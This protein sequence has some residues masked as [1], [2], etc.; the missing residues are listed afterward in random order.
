MASGMGKTD[1]DEEFDAL[2]NAMERLRI[3]GQ[4]EKTFEEKLAVRLP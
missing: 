2:Y 1:S 3:P 4:E